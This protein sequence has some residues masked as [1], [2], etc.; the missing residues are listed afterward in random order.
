MQKLVTL[1][2]IKP[3]WK[4]ASEGLIPS[5]HITHILPQDRIFVSTD[6]TYSALFRGSWRNRIRH[7][8]SNMKY[9][10]LTDY[11]PSI[12]GPGENYSKVLKPGEKLQ[13][14]SLKMFRTHF[15]SLV[16]S[17]CYLSYELIHVYI[18]IL[19]S[20]FSLHRKVLKAATL[21]WLSWGFEEAPLL[22]FLQ[23]FRFCGTRGLKTIIIYQ[24]DFKI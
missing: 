18:I 20:A 14:R 12:E 19:V 4:V 24:K 6:F 5:S 22:W 10:F 3:F 21:L 11:C 2:L 9:I 7:S 15:V 16:M 1:I 23:G 17:I 13:I 8:R